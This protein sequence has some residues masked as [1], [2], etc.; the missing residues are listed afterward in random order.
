MLMRLQQ[1]MGIRWKVEKVGCCVDK[2]RVRRGPACVTTIDLRA[3][4]MMQCR[5]GETPGA[6]TRVFVKLLAGGL[7]LRL[8]VKQQMKWEPGKRSK[9]RAKRSTTAATTEPLF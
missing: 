7:S 9:S 3:Q 8:R 2:A 1:S 4:T 5:D 6:G